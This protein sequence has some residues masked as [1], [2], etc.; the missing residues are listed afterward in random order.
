MA[1]KNE[2]SAGVILYRLEDDGGEHPRPVYLL[3]DYG[4]H[5]DYAKGH[6]EKGED[7]VTAAFRELEE[8]TGITDA[9]RVGDFAYEFTYFFKSKTGGLIR[10]TVIF[11]LAR[12]ERKRAKLSHEHEGYAFL[13]FDEA[14]DRVTY[15]TAKETLRAAHAYLQAHPK[16]AAAGATPTT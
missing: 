8:E 12:T 10:K 5:W 13:P 9:V 7:D 14:V 11:F 2:R 6:V 4:R 15:K 3:L 16:E 1:V